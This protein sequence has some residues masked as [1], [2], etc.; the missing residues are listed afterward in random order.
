[1]A[2]PAQP[3]AVRPYEP[4]KVFRVRIAGDEMAVAGCKTASSGSGPNPGGCLAS[5]CKQ[6]GS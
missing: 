4:P 6:A 2:R 5:F 1:M 3:P